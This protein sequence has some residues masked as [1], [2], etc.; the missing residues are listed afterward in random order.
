MLAEPLLLRYGAAGKLGWFDEADASKS[1]AGPSILS[2][3]VNSL[4]VRARASGPLDS[5][6]TRKG[7]RAYF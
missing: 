1:V 2:S 5:A 4:V 6:N 7:S 3:P